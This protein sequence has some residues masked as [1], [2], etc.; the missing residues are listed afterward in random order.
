MSDPLVLTCRT[1]EYHDAVRASDVLTAAAVI[2]PE[3]LSSAEAA[4]YLVTCLP[5]YPGDSWLTDR[6]AGVRQCGRHCGTG[7]P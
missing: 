3:P 2:E 5:S 1:D 7:L 4:D 6:L